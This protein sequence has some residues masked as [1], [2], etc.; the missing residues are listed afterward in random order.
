M[1]VWTQRVTGSHAKLTWRYSGVSYFARDPLRS[2]FHEPQK[3]N[4]I[5]FLNNSF[6]WGSSK[7]ERNGSRANDHD[8]MTKVFDSGKG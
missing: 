1:E 6:F 2:Y 7:Y 3:I 4:K 5:Y 8:S